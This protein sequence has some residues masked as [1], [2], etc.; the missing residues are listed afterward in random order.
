MRV[1]QGH[2]LGGAALLAPLLA[3]FLPKAIAVLFAVA[4]GASLLC[5]WLAE[6]KLARPPAALATAALAFFLWAAASWLWSMEP[7]ETLDSIL[8]LGATFGGGLVLVGA[9]ARLEPSAIASV[10]RSLLA[11][12]AVGFGLL[13]VEMLGGGAIFNRLLALAGRPM[14]APEYIIYFFNPGLALMALFLWPWAAALW[15]RGLPILA[16]AFGLGAAAVIAA[17][18]AAAPKIALALGAVAALATALWP[19]AAPRVLA[20]A[21]AA[22]VLA[23]PLVPRAFP[24]VPELVRAAPNLPPSLYHRVSIWQVTVRHLA[25]APIMG[26]G[27]DTARSFYGQETQK[28]V[29]LYDKEGIR[30][31]ISQYEPI[32]LHPHNA[33]LQ[34]WLELGAV[35]AL[36]GLVV[37][38]A[39]V[40]GIAGATAAGVARAAASGAFVSGLTI[41]SV[42]FG[43]WQSWWLCGLWLIGAFAA[44]ATAGRQEP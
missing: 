18:D 36:I 42:S 26:H 22:A 39:A 25:E 12:G 34:V 2:V 43:I 44:A 13:A 14:S 7:G 1:H 40:K 37:L 21:V 35:G 4:A 23:A 19:R 6:R 10:E 20:A 8:P 30:R 15:R 3:L 29:A 41:A 33:V 28:E 9:A 17:G 27:L 38:L 16:V 5:S 24:P 11:A 31:W 32:P